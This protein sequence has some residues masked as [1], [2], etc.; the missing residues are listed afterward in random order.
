MVAQAGAA[1]QLIHR[2]IRTPQLHRRRARLPE[3]KLL[4]LIAAVAHPC[5]QPP[6]SR[7]A[8]VQASPVG[9][10]D[11]AGLIHERYGRCRISSSARRLMSNALRRRRLVALWK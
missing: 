2:Y 10:I 9:V 5:P 7:S 3:A 4:V 6:N 8:A 11:I 1:Y